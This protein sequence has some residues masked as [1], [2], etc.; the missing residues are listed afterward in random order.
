MFLLCLGFNNTS[1][2]K[3]LLRERKRHTARRIASTRCAAL[4]NPDL[5]GGGVPHPRSRGRG[6]PVP[7]PGGLPCPRLGGRGT[8]VPG[9]GGYPC[10]RSGG[11]VVHPRSGGYPI[12]RSRGYPVPD[13]GGVPHPRSG[14][15]PIPGLGGYPI[16]TWSGRVTLG[17]PPTQT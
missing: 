14:G 13:P 8:P 17:T 7:D 11:G 4:S 1:N 3:V 6:T 12:P 5:L 2:K 9:P 16:Q 10:P 15:Y